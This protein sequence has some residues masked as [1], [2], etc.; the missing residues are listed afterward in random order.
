[1]AVLPSGARCCALLVVI[2]MA[3]DRGAIEVIGYCV[4]VP[5]MFSIANLLRVACFLFSVFLEPFYY[6]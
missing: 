6:W 5:A 1:M 4:P 3:A 2:C